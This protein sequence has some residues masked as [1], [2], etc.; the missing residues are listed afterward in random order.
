[1]NLRKVKHEFSKGTVG[2]LDKRVRAS[3]YHP[4]RNNSPTTYNAEKD[5]LQ[6]HETKETIKRSQ[7]ELN[8]QDKQTSSPKTIQG[9]PMEKRFFMT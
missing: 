5:K 8:N 1:M 4:Q 6:Q 9:L 2:T 3:S 7:F